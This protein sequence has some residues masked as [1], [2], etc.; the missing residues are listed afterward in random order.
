M[1]S[2]VVKNLRDAYL[3]SSSRLAIEKAPTQGNGGGPALA[4]EAGANVFESRGLHRA[5]S[6]S[7]F[8]VAEKLGGLWKNWRAGLSLSVSSLSFGKVR[9]GASSARS[10]TVRNSGDKKIDVSIFTPYGFSASPSY[11]SLS[12]Q[13]T[14][15][16][17]VTFA[18]SYEKNYSG[19]MSVG[20]GASV[21]LSGE[22][23]S[24]SF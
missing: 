14:R 3:D 24:S 4:S 16:V 1:L 8:R 5:V 21:W 7:E 6:K 10:F 13:E 9:K 22:G 20:G 12:P 18:P 19:S 23:V 2:R 15:Y 11:F 17:S